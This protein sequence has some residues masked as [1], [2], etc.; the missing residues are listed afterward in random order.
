M[1][2]FQQYVQLQ[3]VQ[4]SKKEVSERKTFEENAIATNM[5]FV[6]APRN[7]VLFK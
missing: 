6:F 7:I 5:S 2:T 4:E 3:N 1:E